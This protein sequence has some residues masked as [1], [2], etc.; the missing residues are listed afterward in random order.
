MNSDPQGVYT[1]LAGVY[2]VFLV[3]ILAAII[4]PFWVILK[5]AGFSPWLALINLVPFGTIVL[6]YILAFGEWK[7]FP[8][9]QQISW[10]PP[11]PPLPLG[12]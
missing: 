8:A 6:L 4:F 3:V 2:M 11:Q 12:V 5:K 10:Q 7:V 1:M 9:P